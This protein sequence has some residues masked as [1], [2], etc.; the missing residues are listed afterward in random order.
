[1]ISLNK[2]YKTRDGQRVRLSHIESTGTYPVKGQYWD[3]Y[4]KEWKFASWSLCGSIDV[5]PA[6]EDLVETQP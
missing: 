5:M 2:H 1:M 6:D 4:Y 3:N